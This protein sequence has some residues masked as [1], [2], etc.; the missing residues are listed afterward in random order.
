VQLL[1]RLS[2]NRL[3]SDT[4]AKLT[5]LTHSVRGHQD[6]KEGY[7]T[8]A[9]SLLLLAVLAALLSSCNTTS[10]APTSEVR[11]ALAPTGS[12][13][14]GLNLRRSFLVKRDAATGEVTGMAVDI[15]RMLAE[16]LSVT[17]EPVLY[18]DVG[19]L[20]EGA[21]AGAW[22]IAFLG[23]DPARSDVMEF[24]APYIE[25][26][27]TYLVPV[28]SPI[29]SLAD[30]DRSGVRIGTGLESTTGLFLS[31]TIKHAQLVNGNATELLSAGKA[32]IYAASRNLLLTVQERLSA[33][34]LLDEGFDPVRHAI[35]LPRGRDLAL[36]YVKAFVEE[37]KASG[38]VAAAIARHS[39]R[40][41]NVAPAATR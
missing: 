31:R 33:Y 23:I 1:T 3:K 36:T 16:R 32:D 15:S 12:L 6:A 22:D 19:P 35:A 26:D 41:I 37:I 4:R 17:A 29:Q 9:P 21:R 25:V 8:S 13:R 5:R 11:Q 34:R 39:M 18:P 10:M 27:N 20:V 14:V 28:N 30:A 24:T 2:N 7:V 40:G 38:V